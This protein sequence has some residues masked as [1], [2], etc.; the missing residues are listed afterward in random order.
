MTMVRE[1]LSMRFWRNCKF[2]LAVLCMMAPL[3]ACSQEPQAL[4]SMPL[5]IHTKQNG[6]LMFDIEIA[7]TPEQLERGLMYRKE[8]PSNKGMLFVFTEERE[9]SFWMENTLVPLDMLFIKADGTIAHIHEMA[10]PLDRTPIPSVE[11]VKAVLEILGGESAKQGI[12]IGD[13][14]DPALL[15]TE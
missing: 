8:L 12:K 6:A 10:K 14:I 13:T 7:R 1:R 4:P 9:A 11:K 3:M 15:K 2:V 5:V